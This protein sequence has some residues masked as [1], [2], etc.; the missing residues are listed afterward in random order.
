MPTAR[1]LVHPLVLA[2][3]ATALNAAKPVVVDDAA[4]LAFARQIAAH[5]L[6]P[7]GFELHWYREPEPAMHILAPPVV[8]YWLGAGI[9]V[10]GE[11]VPVLKLTLFPF[12]VVLAY[13]VRSLL[14]RFGGAGVLPALILGPGVLPFINLMLDIPALALQLAAVAVF[15]SA[16]ED[17]P[18]WPR[19]L[20]V[21][22]LTGLALET[23]YSTLVLPPLLLWIGLCRRAIGPATVAVLFAGGLFAGVEYLF[24]VKY[25]ESHFLFHLR[26]ASR[27]GLEES[28]RDKGALL[29]PMLSYLG[30]TAGWIALVGG[31]RTRLVSTCIAGAILAV[32]CFVPGRF[33]DLDPGLTLAQVFF[34][35]IGGVAL[36]IAVHRLVNG[37]RSRL[38]L[39]GWLL[40]EIG[41][42]FA[43]TPFP[44]GRRV[45]GLTV[46][47]A[48]I[49]P[50][51]VG[52]RH[53]PIL[54]GV[55]SG[56][57][58]AA[59]DIWDAR[60]EPTVAAEAIRAGKSQ[61]GR[62]YF[63]GHW[64]FQY[65]CER[66]G[67]KP[68][69]MGRTEL[70][71]GDWVVVPQYPDRVGF[72]RPHD[73]GVEFHPDGRTVLIADLVNDDSLAAETLPALYGGRCPIRSRDHP[74]LR[75]AV[76]AV[77]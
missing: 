45:L 55:V 46:V 41:G 34:D 73:G 28:L 44:A 43:L 57:T 35:V 12:L 26:D 3:V 50:A 52:P 49:V 68:Y 37:D 74:R 33:T 29:F 53:W 64:G 25:G 65:A 71:P 1:W 40:I 59:I 31:G 32:V 66:A 63:L 60:V 36:V 8:P 5:P 62:G 54:V 21:G 16:V 4:Y 9:A 2:A 11:N 24:A 69:L 15:F 22:V 67:L 42:Y 19:V 17:R 27:A 58:L 23:K 48:L 56:L 20:L 10:F 61:P 30:A 51:S 72:Y 13:S 7:F 6:D 47:L 38:L 18:R 14:R 39:A 75:V 70:Q 77:R 76:Y